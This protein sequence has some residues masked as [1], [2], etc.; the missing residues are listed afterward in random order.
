MHV[1][2]RNAISKEST[3]KV[4]FCLLTCASTRGVHLELVENCSAK[5]FLLAFRHFVGRRGLPRVINSDNAKNVKTN[6][7][8]QTYLAL[9]T[10]LALMNVLVTFDAHL[11]LSDTLPIDSPSFLFFF[12]P[13][14]PVSHCLVLYYAIRFTF[15]CLH[16]VLMKSI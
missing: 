6:N 11:S 4:Y 12:I 15:L 1:K 14:C 7:T 9:S 2:K 3:E 8:V 16:F 13:F 5:Q 10:L